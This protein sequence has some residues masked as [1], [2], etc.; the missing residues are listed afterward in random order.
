MPGNLLPETQRAQIIPDD[1][2]HQ[3]ARVEFE[4]DL[5]ARSQNR[6]VVE[7][8][9][10]GCLAEPALPPGMPVLMFRKQRL[11]TYRGIG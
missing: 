11:G 5:A 6:R 2:N 8:G 7:Q 1:R 10:T 9:E 4:G 3:S